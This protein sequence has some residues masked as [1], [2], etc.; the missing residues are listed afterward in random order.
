MKTY[1]VSASTNCPCVVYAMKYV[2]LAVCVVRLLWHTAQVME[3]L[4]AVAA[5]LKSLCQASGV[6]VVRHL[7]LEAIAALSYVLFA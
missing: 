1:G 5:G 4:C 7:V 6:C 2:Q 3:L